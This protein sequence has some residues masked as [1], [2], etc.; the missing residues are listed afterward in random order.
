[1]ENTPSAA[2]HHL[3][4]LE[5]VGIV[6]LHRTEMIHGRTAVFYNVVP[7]EIHIGLEKSD[8]ADIRRMIFENL[9][10]SVY[11]SFIKNASKQKT[12]SG[13]IGDALT[14]VVHLTPQRQ[15]SLIN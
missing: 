5:K 13:V 11:C 12:T 1:M 3:L 10:M 7:G 2:K 4:Q 15:K 8:Y 6:E 9:V 14:G